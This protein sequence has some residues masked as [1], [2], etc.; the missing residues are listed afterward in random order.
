MKVVSETE[1]YI[2][3]DDFL[4]ERSFG[5]IHEYTMMN[6]YA[7]NPKWMKPWDLADSMPWQS[8]E[9]VYH[10]E[11]RLDAGDPRRQY[12]TGTAV[13][14][15]IEKVINTKF[16]RQNFASKAKAMT[17]R[18][19]L[20]PQG[21]SLDWHDDGGRFAGAY[22]FY[23]HRRWHASWGGEFLLIEDELP[24]AMLPEHEYMEGGEVKRRRTWYVID[25]EDLSVLLMEGATRT[26]WFFP[27]PNRILMM[28]GGLW[29]KINLVK[30]NAATARCSIAGFFLPDE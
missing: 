9:T 25:K 12:P 10:P 16:Y 29:H 22:A 21:G 8:G 27:K 24:G 15:F 26:T 3:L 1:N 18:S 20:H 19:Y 13:D 11:K 14:A 17:V 28:R 2:I 30:T 4:D 6:D 5:L 7:R 23:T